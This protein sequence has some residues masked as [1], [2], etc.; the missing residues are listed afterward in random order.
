[1]ETHKSLVKG[2][3]IWLRKFGCGVVLEELVSC[4]ITGEIPDAIG[5]KFGFSY[6]IECKA[7]RSDFLSDKKKV[8][9][10]NPEQGMGA[11][12]FYMSPPHIIEI[13]DLPEGWGLIWR[14]GK[15]METVKGLRCNY[16][17]VVDDKQIKNFTD[18]SLR[19]EIDLLVSALRRS[20]KQSQANSTLKGDSE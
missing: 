5:W 9:R 15:K 8:F 14:D 20:Q 16:S 3:G 18:R 17:N 19:A 6:L 12:R 7:S 2:A 10:R 4:S 13:K 1:M 11:Y